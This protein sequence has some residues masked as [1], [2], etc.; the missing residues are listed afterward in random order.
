MTRQHSGEAGF[1]LFEMLVTIVLL[2]LLS[3]LL[4]GGLRFGVRA[5]DSSEAH[6]T[7][8]DE[9]RVVQGLM[10]RE[11]E[12]AY[13]Y[14]VT[15]DPADPAIDFSGNENAMTFLAPAPQ[16]L[17][18]AGRAR[19][20]LAAEPDGSHVALVMR[21]RPELADGNA[22]GWSEPL[23]RNLAGVRFSY[24]G[25]D[26]SGA[27]PIWHARWPSRRTFPELVRVQVAFAKGDGRIWPDMIVA[28]R[29]ELDAGCVYDYATRYCQGR[30]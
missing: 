2:A 19:V 28:P 1:T 3:L 18:S 13:P 5:W 21:A 23:L 11:I 25:A 4:F 6:G 12:Q 26:S 27:T 9:L 10:R 24:F 29:I 7:G 17:L 14:Y 15:T 16:S 30:K 22:G 20:S 8:M